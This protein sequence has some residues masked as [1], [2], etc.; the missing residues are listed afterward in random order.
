MHQCVKKKKKSF[1]R[2]QERGVVSVPV[3]LTII[4]LILLIMP[5]HP[6]SPVQ[7]RVADHQNDHYNCLLALDELSKV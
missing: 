3:V 2:L 7:F 6:F 5:I 4:K 1:E